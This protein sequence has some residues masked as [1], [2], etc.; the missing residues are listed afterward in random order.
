MINPCLICKDVSNDYFAHSCKECG[1]S[2]SLCTMCYDRAIS[3]L[4]IK[5]ASFLWGL[6]SGNGKEFVFTKCPSKELLVAMTLE[7]PQC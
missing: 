1:D 4:S 5:R 7:G 6:I 2:H 3:L